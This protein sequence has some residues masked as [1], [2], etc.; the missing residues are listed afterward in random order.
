[1]SIAAGG[2]DIAP[3]LSGHYSDI[4][5]EHTQPIPSSYKHRKILYISVLF[6]NSLFKILRICL[7]MAGFTRYSRQDDRAECFNTKA[8]E[9]A[10]GEAQRKPQMRKTQENL[11]SDARPNT[12]ATAENRKEREDA[13]TSQVSAIGM[14]GLK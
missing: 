4:Q 6:K 5:P 7:A 12:R 14:C 10:S 9:S 1:M 11:H 2:D 3:G 13:L 8:A